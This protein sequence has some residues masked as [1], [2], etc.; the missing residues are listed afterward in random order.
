MKC[1][2]ESRIHVLLQFIHAHKTEKILVFCATCA[3]VDY[4][5]NVFHEMNKLAQAQASGGESGGLSPDSEPL[6]PQGYKIYGFHGKMPPVKRNAIYQKFV[7]LDR[8]STTLSNTST[9]SGINGGGGGGTSGSKNS[10]KKQRKKQAKLAAHATATGGS[11]SLTGANADKNMDVVDD[12]GDVTSS[13]NDTSNNNTTN[14][15]TTTTN[16]DTT[17]TDTNNTDVGGLLFCTDVAARGI[18][19]PDVDYIIQWTPPKDPAYYI[20]RIGRTARAGKKGGALLFLSES[21]SAYIELLRTRN[22]AITEITLE[23]NVDKDDPQRNVY[24]PQR[25][26]KIPIIST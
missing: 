26:L 6:I 17:T 14:T 11:T 9:D 25:N 2:Y 23:K 15:T 3:C 19:I 20:H 10:R 16:T 5:S 13:V 21:E 18:D 1:E 7:S 4:Y 8:Q 12:D 24:I 22:V